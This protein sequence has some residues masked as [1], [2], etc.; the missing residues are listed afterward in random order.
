[1]EEK[2]YEVDARQYRK[3]SHLAS[4]DVQLIIQELGSCV[5]TVKEAYY[6][7][8]VMVNGKKENDYFIVFKED[9]K[10]MMVNS[11]NRGKIAQAVKNHD[12]VSLL[13]ANN[14]VNWKNFKI[15]F[16]V[17]ENVS[18]MGKITSG[19]RIK[20][21]IFEEPIDLTKYENMLRGCATL[22]ELQTAF[23]STNFPRVE[24]NALKDKMK[25][26][27]TVFKPKEELQ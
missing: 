2:E 22:G 23:T 4:V 14:L 1:M 13:V 6:G 10:N 3:S 21:V 8:D 16:Y 12:K 26:K 19:I 5:L 20:N 9:V 15:E 11:G 17:D 25:D 18:L 7:R 27:L 24:L